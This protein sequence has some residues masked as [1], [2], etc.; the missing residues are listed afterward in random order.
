MH[1]LTRK[2]SNPIQGSNILLV[3]AH[4]DDEVMFFGPTLIGI[5]NPSNDNNVRVL[6]LSNGMYCFEALLI[7]GNADGLGKIRE[8]ELIASLEYFGIQDVETL[9][10]EYCHISLC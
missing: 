7:V 9:N 4:P 1:A 2:E 3:I 6:C 8:R 10:H 5:T